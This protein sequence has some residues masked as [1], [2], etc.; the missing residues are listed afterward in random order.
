[1]FAP[2]LQAQTASPPAFAIEAADHAVVLIRTT[3]RAS[4]G[5]TVRGIGSGV[6]VDASGLILTAEHVVSRANSLQVHLRSGEALPAEVVGADRVYDLA[7][8][9]V[10]PERLLPVAVLG[11]SSLLQRGETVVALGR[12]PR[13]QAGPTAGIFL[14]ASLERAGVPDLVST[15]VVYPG[16]SG[17]A[18]VNER[19]EVV[20]IILAITG[21]GLV[22]LARASDAVRTILVDLRVG[23]VRHPWLGITGRTLTEDLAAQLGV[24]VHSGVLIIEVLPNSP[25]SL[26]GLRGAKPTSTGEFPAGGDIIVGV[27]GRPVTTFGTLA[28]YVLSKHIGDAITL[29]INRDGHVFTT[30]VVLGERPTL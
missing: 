16:D 12:A 9:R 14:E 4:N 3:Y 19:G 11:V 6:I 2:S 28:A 21:E 29:E 27:D 13:R 10:N 7:L 8:V 17:G 5:R 23:D 22:S 1:M 20:G 30:T 26:A 18:L 15:A 24:G 25:A